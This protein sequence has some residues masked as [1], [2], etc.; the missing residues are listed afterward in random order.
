MASHIYEHCECRIKLLH[1]YI[2]EIEGTNKLSYQ[3]PN[4]IYSLCAS[5]HNIA[6]P[7]QYFPKF[8]NI[9]EE[10]E[11]SSESFEWAQNM[12]QVAQS[13]I[14]ISSYTFDRIWDKF[15]RKKVGKF[16]C[17]RQLSRLVYSLIALHVK[18][19]DRNAKPPKFNSLQS[20]L[21]SICNYIELQL[22]K[23]QITKQEFRDKVA[24]YLR[25]YALEIKPKWMDGSYSEFWLNMTTSLES[26]SVEKK[27]VI[28][29]LPED[30]NS[31]MDF[32]EIIGYIIKQQDKVTLYLSFYQCRLTFPTLL[33]R[34]WNMQRFILTFRALVD[35]LVIIVDQ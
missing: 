1:G 16:D 32:V 21:I 27:S 11:Q 34:L 5:Y 15:D 7:K 12:F 19:K 35:I 24:M 13:M 22:Q 31:L 20:L 33:Y 25:Q 8:R 26:F 28:W 10:F 14:L 2:H 23:Y 17:H 4:G 30:A 9:E 29:E 18:I 3:V 6:C